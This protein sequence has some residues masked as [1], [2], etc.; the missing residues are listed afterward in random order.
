MNKRPEEVTGWVTQVEGQQEWLDRMIAS[1]ATFFVGH[2]GGKDS[3]AMAAVVA[4]LVPASQIVY[5]HADLGRFEWGTVDIKTHIRNNLPTG[6]ELVVANA[7]FNDG[8]PKDFLSKVEANNRRIQNQ[9]AD[10]SHKRIEAASPWPSQANRFCTGELKTAPIWKVIRNTAGCGLSKKQFNKMPRPIVVNCVGIRAEE[11]PRRSQLEPL[12]RNVANDNAAR[13][14]YDWY[15]IFDMK[16]E[17]VWETI[18]NSGQTRHPAYD[19]G[20]QRLSCMFCIFG[21][22]NDLRNGAQANPSLY[23]EMVQAEQRYGFSM[24]QSRKYLTEI[25]GLEISSA[26]GDVTVVTD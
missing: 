5:V 14:A 19:A 18:E 24:H 20:N 2:S 15:P 13:E 8:Q 10:P 21:S 3:Q 6:A 9:V 11:S 26:I 22:T 7:V 12:S 17:E 4:S 25:T 23:R 16:I 1:N